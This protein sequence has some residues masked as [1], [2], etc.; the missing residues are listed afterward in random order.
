MLMTWSQNG[1]DLV[2]IDKLVDSAAHG[3]HNNCSLEV[4]ET[5]TTLGRCSINRQQ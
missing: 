4:P 2:G 5:R 3:L 1:L